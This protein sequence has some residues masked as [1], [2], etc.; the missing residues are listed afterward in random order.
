MAQK[1]TIPINIILASKSPRRKQLLEE[2]GVKFVAYTGS[3]EVDESL[4]PDLQA[5]PEEAVK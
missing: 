2:A 3:S 1:P 4:E 5:N